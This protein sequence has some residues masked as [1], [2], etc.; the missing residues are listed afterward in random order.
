[1]LKIK[2]IPN[3]EQSSD[4]MASTKRTGINHAHSSRMGSTSSRNAPKCKRCK[5]PIP[6]LTDAAHAI[7]YLFTQKQTKI[8]SKAVQ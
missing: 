3:G 1:M 7:T 8:H 2:C 5:S 6:A 4:N